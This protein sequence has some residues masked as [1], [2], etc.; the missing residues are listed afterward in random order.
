MKRFLLILCLLALAV[1][2]A[3]ALA[4]DLE[5]SQLIGIYNTC[6]D[7]PLQP[8]L[9]ST[10]GACFYPCSQPEEA[11]HRKPWF[12]PAVQEG[13]VAGLGRPSRGWRGPLGTRAGHR[14]RAGEKNGCAVFGSSSMSG[15]RLSPG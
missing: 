3:T 9:T 1:A 2:P 4:V 10:L 6:L 7:V 5:E 11:S 13:Q 15:V 8:L 12:H 14:D